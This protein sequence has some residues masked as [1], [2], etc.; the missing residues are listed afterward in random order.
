MLHFYSIVSEIEPNRVHLRTERI[1]GVALRKNNFVREIVRISS[2]K[3][4]DI[5]GKVRVVVLLRFILFSCV[6]LFDID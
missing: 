1:L 3:V 4:L 2:L 5:L 6:F